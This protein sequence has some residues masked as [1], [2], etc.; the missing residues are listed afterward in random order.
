M[1]QALIW[2]AMLSHEAG[3]LGTPFDAEDLERLADALVDGVRGNLQLG[4]NLLRRHM[5]V[6]QA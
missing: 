6:D 4:R 1:Y 2:P 5:L 3:G